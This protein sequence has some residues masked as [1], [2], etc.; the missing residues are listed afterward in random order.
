MKG[1]MYKLLDHFY[2]DSEE[3]L[4]FSSLSNLSNF[5]SSATYLESP[6]NKKSRQINRER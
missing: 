1:I 6:T 5:L 4:E 3:F 2:L